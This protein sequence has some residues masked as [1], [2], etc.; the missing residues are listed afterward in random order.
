M[1]L[2]AGPAV[3]GGTMMCVALASWALGRWQGGVVM[4][5]ESGADQP[6]EGSPASRSPATPRA[7]M[8]PAATGQHADRDKG[9]AALA[10]ASLGELHAEISAYRQAE[11]V[12]SQFD[13]ALLD[14]FDEQREQRARCRYL[15]AMGEPTCAISGMLREVCASDSGCGKASVMPLPVPAAQPSPFASGLSRV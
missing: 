3:L 15:N 14:Q 8:A 12:L 7:S 9:H 1:D 6:G 4:P 11:Q 2:S 5:D 10:G 13:G